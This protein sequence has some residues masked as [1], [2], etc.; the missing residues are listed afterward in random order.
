M[1]KHPLDFSTRKALEVQLG[2]TPGREI[3]DVMFQLAARIEQLERTKV[4]KT[5]IVPIS[6][7]MNERT[8]KD[9]L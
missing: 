9:Q 6:G 3:A 4:D 2:V 1:L 5:M 8:M 7:S